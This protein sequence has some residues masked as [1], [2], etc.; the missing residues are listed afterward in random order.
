MNYLFNIYVFDIFPFRY[1]SLSIFFPFDIFPFDIFLFDIFPFFLFDIFPFRYFSFRHFYCHPLTLWR[2]R[3][4]KLK[5]PKVYRISLNQNYYIAALTILQVSRS[6]GS[7]LQVIR[8]KIIH[9]IVESEEQYP[10]LYLIYLRLCLNILKP[11]SRKDQQ[12]IYK[13]ETINSNS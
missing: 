5:I 7:V 12:Q 1:F 8:K 2:M 6:C 11:L 3:A 13:F 9:T 10:P 4:Q